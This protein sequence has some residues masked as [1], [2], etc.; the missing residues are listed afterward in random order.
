M[1][2]RKGNLLDSPASNTLV[3]E[4]NEKRSG[5]VQKGPGPT[6]QKI[7]KGVSERTLF[8]KAVGRGTIEGEKRLGE[9]NQFGSKKTKRIHQ[10]RSEIRGGAKYPMREGL[11]CSASSGAT[12]MKNGDGFQSGGGLGGNPHPRK[13]EH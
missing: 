4:K 10:T 12:Q 13:T 7:K 2:A 1:R 11:R 5:K 9:S 3:S 6:G 8:L